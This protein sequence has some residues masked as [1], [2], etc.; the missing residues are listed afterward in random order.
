M[1]DQRFVTPEIVSTHFSLRPGDQV[2]DFGAGIGNFTPVLS[3]LV[4]PEG[5]VYASEI[6]KNLVDKLTDKIRREHLSN[7]QVVWGDI[8]ELGGT[9]IAEGS[10]DAAIIVNTLFQIEDKDT[11]LRE[12]AR[13]LR[14]GGKLFVIDWSESWSGMGPQPGQVLTEQSARDLCESQG[15]TFERSFDAGGHHYGLAFRK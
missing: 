4:G 6:Q 14:V 1:N 11:A 10:L 9:N 7:T 15:F 12:I 2:G 8:E 13:T 3:R 5:R